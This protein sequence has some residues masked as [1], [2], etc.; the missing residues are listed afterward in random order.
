MTT[1]PARLS[2]LLALLAALPIQAQTVDM[3]GG[4]VAEA[5]SREF[6]T[7]ARSAT[8]SVVN[9]STTSVVPGRRARIP[10]FFD[11]LFGGELGDIFGEPARQ[12]TSLGSGV[13]F[14]A[15]GYIVT[16]NHVVAGGTQIAVKLS[17]DTNY[18]G[19]LVGTDA[20]S[21]LAV[22]R[23][24]QGGL[25]AIHWG[26][27]DALEVGEWVI[28]IGSPLGLAQTVTAGIIS[29]KGR[30]DI[31]LSSYEDFIQTDAAINPG[32]SGG[33]LVNMKGELVGVNTAIASQSGGY[34]GIGFAI[35]S[36]VA[37]KIAQQLVA[38]GRIVRGWIGI[39]PR[40]LTTEEAGAMP[41]RSGVAISQMYKDQPAHRAGLLPGDIITGWGEQA[42]KSQGDLGR[43]VADARIGSTIQV[44]YLRDGKE[45]VAP[46][47][48]GKR[49]R[50]VRGRAM[51]GV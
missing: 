34:E 46:V 35:P 3:H 36:N 25:P 29:A 12:V 2:V 37:L 31:G 33:A 20:L 11:N 9:I 32:N 4:S 45:Q 51:P 23:I 22:V 39:I 42:V 48:M 13:I 47:Q 30:H 17:N 16:N 50:D 14:S 19:Q 8:P 44:R 49:P 27:S 43:L 6:A 15:D 26:D 21:D 24:I 7:V 10:S 38:K 1:P 41:G 40:G 5:L 28:A 18:T